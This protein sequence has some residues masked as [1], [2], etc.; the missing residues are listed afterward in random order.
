MTWTDLYYAVVSTTNGNGAAWVDEVFRACV[1]LL[2]FVA[3]KIGMTYE[4]INIWI[5]VILW[6]L[7]TIY[8]TARITFLQYQIRKLRK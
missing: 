3:D 2:V 6:P 4:E 8:Q 1:V 5:F 7:L